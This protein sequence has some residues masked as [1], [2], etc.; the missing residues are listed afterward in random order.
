MDD[1]G[2]VFDPEEYGTPNIK[3]VVELRLYRNNLKPSRVMIYNDN[4]NFKYHRWELRDIDIPCMQQL[5]LIIKNLF[6]IARMFITTT[7]TGNASE[8]IRQGNKL[9][10]LIQKLSNLK[11]EPVSTMSAASLVRSYFIYSRFEP[12]ITHA[13]D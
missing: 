10:V 12:F 2:L 6:F 11:V 8:A 1:L 4:A 13:N 5:L 9:R 7:L 3:V